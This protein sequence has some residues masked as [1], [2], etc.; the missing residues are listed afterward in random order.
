MTPMTWGNDITGF[1]GLF[2]RCWT[3]AVKLGTP[4]L[5]IR[6]PP[7][8]VMSSVTRRVRQLDIMKS[9]HG[10]EQLTS[11]DAATILVIKLIRVK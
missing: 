8:G 9:L 1:A 7:W 5:H 11:T 4:E 6:I 10:S 2:T 3:R